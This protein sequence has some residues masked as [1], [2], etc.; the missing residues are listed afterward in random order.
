M[1]RKL[2]QVAGE[3]L[4]TASALIFLYLIYNAWFTNV[5]ALAQSSELAA[6]I[7]Q[8]FD[9]HDAKPL[10][11]SDNSAPTISQGTA[12]TPIGLLYIPRLRDQ[13]WGLPIV[14]GVGHLELS[15]GVGHYS[16]T[17]L[18]GEPG[19][20]AIA[21]HR[22][23]NGEPFAYF[24]RLQAGDLVYVRTEVG[25]F[26]YQLIA[27]KKIQESETWVLSDS[28]EGLSIEPGAALITLTT[29]DPRWNSVRRW[30]WWGSLTK[31]Y[32]VGEVPSVVGEDG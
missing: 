3:I 22:A 28:P 23:T 26:E 1:S 24:E 19:N 29:C 7:E 17:N 9:L 4:V 11:T 32:L 21:G 16:T 30:A 15:L 10:A 18:P 25:W 8:S 14:E 6:Q 20:F 12:V 13:V 31:T 27:N 5:T 2:L